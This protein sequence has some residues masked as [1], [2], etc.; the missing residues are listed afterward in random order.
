[1]LKKIWQ[2]YWYWMIFGLLVFVSVAIRFYLLGNVPHGMTWDEAA[3]GYNGY[4]IF[5]TRRDEWLVRLPVSFR[6]FGDYKAPLAIYLNGPFS[7]LFGM[8]LWAVRLPFAI[9]SIMTIVGF[10]LLSQQIFSRV[11]RFSLQQSLQ[12]SLVCGFF[13]TFSPWHIQFSRAGFESGLALMFSLWGMIFLLDFLRQKNN[14]N[15]WKNLFSIGS[16]LLSAICFAAAMYSYHS[17][18]IAIPL[19]IAI[20]FLLFWKEVWNQK[21]IVIVQGVWGFL[22]LWPMIQDMVWASGSQRFEQASIFT[23]PIS[24]QEKSLL[25]VQNFFTHFTIHYLIFGQTDTLRHGDG[26][27]GVLFPSTFFCVLFAV[28]WLIVK[29]KKAKKEVRNLILFAIGWIVIGILPAAVSRSVPHSNRALFALPGYLLLAAAGLRQLALELKKS[30]LNL[31]VSGS[32]K[33]ANLLVKSV[34]GMFF[35]LEILFACSYL[36]HYFTVFAKESAADFQDGYLE[37]MKFASENEASSD[38]IIFTSKYG[39]P[40][41]YAIFVRK[42]N[43]IW[44]QGG[45]L[46]KYEFTDVK[47]SDLDRKNTVIVAT[48]E[49]I[50]P[51]FGQKLVYGSDGKVRFVM[52]KTP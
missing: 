44:Y 47:Q 43:P 7:F 41:I 19:M 2:K 33:E 17:A 6:S 14:A 21:I 29:R 22:L 12:L 49:E 9:A 51:K 27:W 36:H 20:L 34:L 42:T 35:L 31:Q 13:M 23:L 10:M 38:R 25:F 3:I 45:S 40:Y 32:K 24:I 30:P 50:D 39:Q 5:T 4:A 8:N 26:S 18:K 11:G 16:A 15:I 1:M 37:A 28:G 52:L 46:I 48:P